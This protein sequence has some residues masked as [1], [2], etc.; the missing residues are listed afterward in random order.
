MHYNIVL[1][2]AVILGLIFSCGCG[3]P[4]YGRVK[5]RVTC[6]GKPFEHASLTFSPIPK[7]SDDKTPGRSSGGGTDSNGEYRL[8]NSASDD[9]VVVGKH[10]VSVAVEYPDRPYPCKGHGEI[11][12]EVRPGDNEINIELS[13][14]S[15][16][17]L[18]K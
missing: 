1:T 15:S 6:N 9:R 13:D 5:G 18:K 12:V 16:N 2:L 10:R 8:M 4:P 3:S 14:Y 11:I 17:Q 7:S